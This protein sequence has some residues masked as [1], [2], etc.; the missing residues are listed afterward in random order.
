M[1]AVMEMCAWPSDDQLA[2]KRARV[3]LRVIIITD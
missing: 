2:Y 1:R 3:Q